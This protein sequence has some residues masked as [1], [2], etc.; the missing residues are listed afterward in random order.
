VNGAEHYAEAERL[1]AYEPSN[2]MHSVA[3]AFARDR[4]VA[5]AGV[6]ATLAL[7]A[8]TLYRNVPGD[9]NAGW[10]DA[11]GHVSKPPPPDPWGSAP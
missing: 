1:L 3:Q 2:V 8:A 9:V 10:A 4:A 11:L 7:A 6:H 5:R